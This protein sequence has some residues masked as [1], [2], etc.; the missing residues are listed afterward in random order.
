VTIGGAIANILTVPSS[1]TVPAAATTATF[2]AS[3]GSIGSDLTATITASLNGSSTS[4][5]LAL[6]A[7]VLVSSL[8]CAT[9]TLASNASTTCTVTLTKAA[10][11]GGATV[12]IGG[13]IANILT[14]PPSV[15]IAAPATTAT[16]TATA[17]TIA[18]AQTA[19]L[20]ATYGASSAATSLA[21]TAPLPPPTL[22]TLTCSPTSVQPGTSGTCTVGLSGPTTS[23]LTIVLKS[24]NTGLQVPA[25]L[26]IATGATG[27]FAYTTSSTLSGWLIITATLGATRKTATLTIAAQS[28][29]AV[30]LSCPGPVTAGGR[31]VCNL[32]LR[33][34]PTHQ[35]TLRLSSSSRNLT[36]PAALSVRPGQRSIRFQAV[37]GDSVAAENAIV[38]VDS[39]DGTA[40]A[41]I[42][43]EPS[44]APALRIAG[45]RTAAAGSTVHLQISTSSGDGPVTLSASQLPPGARFDPETG[46]LMWSP[47]TSQIGD[48]RIVLHAT[49]AFGTSTTRE[50]GI[51][52]GAGTPEIAGLMNV[53]GS[54]APAACV[55]GAAAA[56]TG[57]FLT[58]SETSAA[59]PAATSLELNGAQVLVNGSPAAL[60]FVSAGRIDFICPQHPAG[61]ALEIVV[62]SG[63]RSSKPLSAVMAAD[64]PGILVVDE[65]GSGQALAYH[66]GS[67]DIVALPNPIYP[68][69]PAVA[70]EFVSLLV[71][72]L[73]CEDSFQSGRP[74]LQLGGR[75]LSPQ[76]V[77][78]APGYAG[79]CELT[80][81]VPQGISTDSLPVRLYIA[82]YDGT[83][84]QSNEVSIAVEGR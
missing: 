31:L 61:A 13:A 79:A 78:T 69:Q 67:A 11:A 34:P 23:P 42:D 51:H 27:T 59:D 66:T 30:S 17:G 56:L 70:G 60:L 39:E 16:F 5:S 80:F 73:H 52:V 29:P 81:E 20:T 53:A 4:V 38:S 32:D 45:G 82:H 10:P 47:E 68:A 40:Q 76:S 49:N 19:V 2:T 18:T 84:A 36:P 83:L 62:R 3:S 24:S 75:V 37:I 21:L 14:L 48:H 33:R 25:S 55:A 74:Q 44:H 58:N 7:S 57:N 71:T 54:R 50:I 6:S 65:I 22:S 26:S 1:V 72:G 41:S 35:A 8:Q 77:K 12:S 63:A 15:T 43:I 9:G 64:A 46:D 28:A